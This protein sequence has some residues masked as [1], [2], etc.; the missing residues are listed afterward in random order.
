MHFDSLTAIAS[1]IKKKDLSPVEVTAALLR[2]IDEVDPK[3]QSYATVTADL[4]MQQAQ[5][6]EDE[7]GAGNYRGPLHGVP[8]ALKDLCYTAGVPTKGGLRVRSDFVPEYD[9]T[10][11]QRLADAGAVLLLSLIHI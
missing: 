10:V 8:I 6:A 7:I 11:V 2:R 3:L 4:A 5:H 1:R 9:G